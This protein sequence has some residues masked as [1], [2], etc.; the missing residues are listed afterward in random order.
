MSSFVEYYVN[1]S[2]DKKKKSGKNKGGKWVD[3]MTIPCFTTKVR[4]DDL[5]AMDNYTIRK[6]TYI[7]NIK[8][9]DDDLCFLRYIIV[10]SI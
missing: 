8:N 10:T 3:H 2:N 5:K 4:T 9:R 6:P 1:L 7:Y